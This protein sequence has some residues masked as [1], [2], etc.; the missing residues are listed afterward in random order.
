MVSVEK[1][2]LK[3]RHYYHVF[4][5]CYIQLSTLFKQAFVFDLSFHPTSSRMGT[6][7]TIK[8]N[9]G[10]TNPLAHVFCGEHG[11][12][13]TTTAANTFSVVLWVPL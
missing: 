9:M 11:W 3:F 7:L 6:F 2:L 4:C 12:M 5:L 8:L 1:W 10:R 13:F